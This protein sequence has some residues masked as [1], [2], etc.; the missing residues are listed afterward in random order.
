MWFDFVGH[1]VVAWQYQHWCIRRFAISASLFGVRLPL[2]YPLGSPS[3]TCL[4]RPPDFVGNDEAPTHE[5]LNLPPYVA[6][7]CGIA[8]D[9]YV[10]RCQRLPAIR[11]R[12]DVII[13]VHARV[14]S[15]DVKDN[16]G[17]G[18]RARRGRASPARQGEPGMMTLSMCVPRKWPKGCGVHG[19]GI[20]SKPGS[21]FL[22]GLALSVRARG[23]DTEASSS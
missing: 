23:R 1:D 13:D 16:A 14:S 7:R 11:K 4:V 9:T 8:S 2:R 21:P 5:V 10:D 22:V 3:G 19:N 6:R 20:W 15:V 12:N 18:G 17:E